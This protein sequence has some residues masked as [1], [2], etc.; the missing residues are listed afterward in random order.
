MLTEDGW[1]AFD[2]TELTPELKLT[3]YVILQSSNRAKTF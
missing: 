3:N 2:T 1:K